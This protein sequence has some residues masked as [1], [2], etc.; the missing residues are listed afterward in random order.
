MHTQR[1]TRRSRICFPAAPDWS[2]HA[3]IL[4]DK[5]TSKVQHRGSISHERPHLK[6]TEQRSQA[7]AITAATGSKTG[8][9]QAHTG[10]QR[11]H[12]STFHL[13]RGPHPLGPLRVCGKISFIQVAGRFG[14]SSP[15]EIFPMQEWDGNDEKS[16][17]CPLKLGLN[18]TL[19]SKQLPNFWEVKRDVLQHVQPGRL[20]GN[21][22]S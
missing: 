9:Q 2:L 7:G 20:I 18:L 16:Q 10:L 1:D 3:C 6:E 4:R 5:G 14:G 22:I 17:L 11:A 15:L 8:E 19:G 12:P 21:G 13:R